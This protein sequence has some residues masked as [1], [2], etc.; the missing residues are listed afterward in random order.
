KRLTVSTADHKVRLWDIASQKAIKTFEVD[1]PFAVDLSFDGGT[2]AV[3]GA[4]VPLTLFDLRKGTRKEVKRFPSSNG[5][6]CL[7]LTRDGKGL[8]AH[9]GLLVVFDPA[10]GKRRPADVVGHGCKIIA[11]AV[12]DDGRFLA[13]VGSREDEVKVWRL[14]GW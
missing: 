11:M 9:G 8:M 1:C 5:P 3:G 7:L 4:P 6:G 14:A 10:T 2:L 12:S 13:T